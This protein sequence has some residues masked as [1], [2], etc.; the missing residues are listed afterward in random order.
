MHKI[1]HITPQILSLFPSISQAQTPPFLQLH[2]VLSTI[3]SWRSPVQDVFHFVLY[4]LP[5]VSADWPA[6]PFFMYF[7][8]ISCSWS[9][10]CQLVLVSV[11]LLSLFLTI[12]NH[13]ASTFLFSLPFNQSQRG[14]WLAKSCVFCRMHIL[15][16]SNMLRSWDNNSS[17]Q[18]QFERSPLVTG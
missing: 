17:T 18:L 2:H 4:D 15:T 3:N 8:L 16:A 1:S 11:S 7:S 9:A 6:P 14:L 13:N 12:L 10:P 5:H